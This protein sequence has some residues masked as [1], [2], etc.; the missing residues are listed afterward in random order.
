MTLI[1]IY[2]H[3]C[4]LPRGMRLE[5]PTK[6]VLNKKWIGRGAARF[7]LVGR[8]SFAEVL[9]V[10]FF[11][12]D[13]GVFLGWHQ[14]PPPHLGWAARWLMHRYLIKRILAEAFVLWSHSVGSPSFCGSNP[15]S[16]VTSSSRLN[17]SLWLHI[18]IK[19]R[20]ILLLIYLYYLFYFILLWAAVRLMLVSGVYSVMISLSSVYAL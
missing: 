14:T 12:W 10:F 20:I 17:Y 7:L 16:V 1:G 13:I 18:W 4:C 11:R 2:G 19:F 15:P 3:L 6:N 5:V 9:R 8:L